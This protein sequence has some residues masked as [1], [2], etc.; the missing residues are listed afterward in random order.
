MKWPGFFSYLLYGSA[1]DYPQ[2]FPPAFPGYPTFVADDAPQYPFFP[3]DFSGHADPVYA[4]APSSGY[5]DPNAATWTDPNAG[6]TDP[7]GPSDPSSMMG[8][9]PATPPGGTQDEE[10]AAW[11]EIEKAQQMRA[12]KIQKQMAG[13]A[14]TPPWRAHGSVAQALVKP[15]PD[16]LVDAVLASA[17]VPDVPLGILTNMFGG[18][19]NCLGFRAY[20]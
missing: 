16:P 19:E 3:Q 7:S 5:T 14:A 2:G 11:F 18:S 9:A 10:Q 4:S 6:W 13:L 12:Q 15:E 8:V 17:A 20:F 1:W